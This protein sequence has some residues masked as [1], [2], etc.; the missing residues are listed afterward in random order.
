VVDLNSDAGQTTQTNNAVPAQPVVPLAKEVQP[1]ANDSATGRS[2]DMNSRMARLEQQMDYVQKI[3][4]SAKFEQL[5]QAVADLRG[6]IDIQGQQLK[7]LENQQR[8]L[9]ADLDQ[10]IAALSGKSVS[11]KEAAPVASNASDK[12]T[13]SYQ[14]AFALIT[15]KKYTAAISALNDYL[16]QYPT[17]QF[18]ANAHYWLGELYMIAGNNDAAINQFNLVVSNYGTSCKAADALLKLAEIAFNNTRFD[19]AR[20]YWQTIINKYPNCSAARIA[21][22]KLQKL[23]KS[24]IVS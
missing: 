2:M 21:K 24:A 22:D 3:N 5:Q 18:A 6:L 14:S 19:Q 7:Q 23:Q 13:Q 9:Y 20:Q 16:R 10:R 8:S 11:P 12:E 1:I 17:G 4:L 15:A